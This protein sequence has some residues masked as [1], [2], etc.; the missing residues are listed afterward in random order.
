MLGDR[1]GTSPKI[2]I[3]SFWI[4][5]IVRALSTLL[6]ISFLAF[7]FLELAPGDYLDRMRLNPQ[8]SRETLEAM[9]VQYGLD[10]P[11]LERYW[12]WLRAV[13]DGT[14]GFSFAYG[15]AVAPLIWA[16][17]LNTLLLSVCASVV[18]WIAAVPIGA[19]WATR[20]NGVGSFL[21][22]VTSLCVGLPELILAVVALVVA[23]RSG[24]L[25]VGG[26]ASMGAS[27]LAPFERA[28]DLAWHLVLPVAVLALPAFAL[29]T[30]HV[31][32][33]IEDVMDEPFIT[34]ARSFGISG[35]R[36]VLHH[37]LRP[38]ASPLISIAGLSI[39]SLLSASFVV[40][41]VMGWPGLG[42]FLLDA[43]QARDVHVVIGGVMCSAVLVVAGGLAADLV[44]YLNDPRI[45][46]R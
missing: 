21:G 3:V 22:I 7:L 36:L 17:A 4:R 11:F 25:P 1:Q 44:H 24:V 16:R 15:S 34:R 41:V 35:R 43:I 9:R 20:N 33:A 29:L 23:Q 6:A 46:A 37:M 26:M 39:A 18:A 28:R 27:D 10:R 19:L 42:P 38:A 12:N 13:A 32:S 5:R 2:S 14:W 8:I 30:R 40:E 45:D 31:R